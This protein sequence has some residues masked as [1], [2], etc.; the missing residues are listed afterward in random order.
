[1]GLSTED[2]M[3]VPLDRCVNRS[4]VSIIPFNPH[5]INDN[6]IVLLEWYDIV[7]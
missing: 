6:D 1:M 2:F 4:H 7:K 3:Q 5:D